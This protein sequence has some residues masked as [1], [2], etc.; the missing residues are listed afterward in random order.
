MPVSY[1]DLENAYQYVS[2]ALDEYAVYIDRETGRTY[3]EMDDQIEDLPEDVD[4]DNKYLCAPSQYDLNLGKPLVIAFTRAH[5]PDDTDRV[6][7]IFSSRGAYSRFKDF[8]Q[9]TG[10]LDTWYQFEQT[11]IQEAL[12]QWCRQNDL[13]LTP[14]A[15]TRALVDDSA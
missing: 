12:T 5:L 4:N 3:W 14:D 6:E 10:Q 9:Q 2:S 1:F 7:Q 8:L 15:P 13:E 11:A